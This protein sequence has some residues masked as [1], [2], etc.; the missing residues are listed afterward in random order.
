MCAVSAPARR[1]TIPR[2]RSNDRRGSERAYVKTGA[3]G[4]VVGGLYLVDT[5][6]LS[7]YDPKPRRPAV[8]I[9]LPPYGLSDPPVLTR[10][11]DTS[12]R[13]VQHPRNPALQL[14]K[15]GVFG[16]QYL[17]HLN[18]GHFTASPHAVVFLGMLEE[19]YFAKVL[20][21]WER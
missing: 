19:E 3:D 13:G 7:A 16:Y 14:S 9:A 2:S 21:W 5:V 12:I 20:T 1:A 8:V 6:L 11:S 4:P 17:R 18:I 15:D 10:T